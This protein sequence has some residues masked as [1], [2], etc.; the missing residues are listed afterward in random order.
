M[1]ADT[2][3]HDESVCGSREIQTF[4]SSIHSVL[5]MLQPC[6]EDQPRSFSLTTGL[7]SRLSYWIMLSHMSGHHWYTSHCRHK[8]RRLVL[9]E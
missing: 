6:S 7:R 4:L 9:I 5:A 1:T 2:Q 3:C 8:Y